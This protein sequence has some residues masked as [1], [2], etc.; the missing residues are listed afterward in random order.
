MVHVGVLSGG[1]DYHYDYI[2]GKNIMPTVRDLIEL[3]PGLG[4]GVGLE[5][6]DRAVVI[7]PGVGDL[8]LTWSG[9]EWERLTPGIP[10]DT[11]RNVER[12]LLFLL[13]IAFGVIVACGVGTVFWGWFW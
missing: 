6:D 5:L 4:E 2:W 7:F 8:E 12:V 11:T 13:F 3:V 9:T 10:I 1:L